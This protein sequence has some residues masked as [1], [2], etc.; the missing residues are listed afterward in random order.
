MTVINLTDSEFRLGIS[1]GTY[2][3]ILALKQGHK[4]TYGVDDNADPWDRDIEGACAEMSVAKYTNQYW[5][6]PVGP[7]PGDVGD[8]EVRYTERK[9]NSLIVRESDDDEAVFILVTG[10]APHQ[11]VVGWLHGLDAKQ[12]KYLSAKGTN[13]P[14]AW[15]VPQCD[16]R[17]M[18]DLLI[19]LA[20]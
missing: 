2:R 7:K 18:D 10:K 4:G 14:P 15:F 12:N 9:S 19:T 11:D 6:G 3:H 5:G 20:E 17:Q 16:L 13:R 8:L 1:V